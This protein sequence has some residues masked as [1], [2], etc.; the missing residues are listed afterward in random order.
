MLA[1][2][3]CVVALVGNKVRNFKSKRLIFVKMIQL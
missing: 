1:G 3:E 2:S